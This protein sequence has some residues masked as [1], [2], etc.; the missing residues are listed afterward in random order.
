MMKILAT[1]KAIPM[2]ILMFVFFILMGSEPTLLHGFDD[3]HLAQLKNTNNCRKCDLTNANLTNA[4]L[5]SADLTESNLSGANLTNAYLYLANLTNVKIENANLTNAHLYGA[6]LKGVKMAGAD[7]SGATWT[8][9]T[10]CKQ[11]SIG[12]CDH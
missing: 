9:G 1:R 6:L 11:H 10:K 8:N 3:A 7:L 2:K 5:M 12:K 4:S